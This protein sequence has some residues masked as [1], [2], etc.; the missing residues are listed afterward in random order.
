[1]TIITKYNPGDR[2]FLLNTNKIEERNIVEVLSRGYKKGTNGNNVN[3]EYNIN[4]SLEGIIPHFPE[5][6]LFN[7]K[8]ELLE[9]L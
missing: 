7:T 5:D 8:Q 9:S 1:M 4:Y 6:K 3:S 2:V